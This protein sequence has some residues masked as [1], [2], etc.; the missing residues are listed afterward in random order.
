M[1]SKSSCLKA[2]SSRMVGFF[3]FKGLLKHTFLI[4]LQYLTHSAQLVFR[5]RRREVWINSYLMTQIESSF[6]KWMPL[7]SVWV[8]KPLPNAS[9]DDAGSGRPPWTHFKY[10]RVKMLVD[11]MGWTLWVLWF[12]T[13]ARSCVLSLEVFSSVI[14]T[15]NDPLV[16]NNKKRIQ[17][18]R[19]RRTPI[20]PVCLVLSSREHSRKT[21]LVFFWAE[22]KQRSSWVLTFCLL[23]SAYKKLCAENTQLFIMPLI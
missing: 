7:Q 12:C 18:G 3:F 1:M 19:K 9:K 5:R 15:S 14:R 22:L 20:E 13:Y 17:S 21:Q 8:Q 10:S 11:L 16:K 23:K 6:H 2:K 4:W